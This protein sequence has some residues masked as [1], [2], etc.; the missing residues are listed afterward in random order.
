MSKAVK[1]VTKA[2]TAPIKKVV[3]PINEIRKDVTKA[4]V[5]KAVYNPISQT[6][7]KA[8][9][10][11]NEARKDVT[12]SG[13][14]AVADVVKPL[15]PAGV[16][17]LT[18]ALVASGVG[19]PLAAALAAGTATAGK[20]VDRGASLTQAGKAGLLSGGISGLAGYGGEALGGYLNPM[21]TKQLGSTISPEIIKTYL[22]PALTGGTI[23]GGLGSLLMGQ[24]FGQGFLQGAGNAV[25]GAGIN[26]WLGSQG[27]TD[28]TAK[29][30]LG[31][32]IGAK[33]AP[34]LGLDGESGGDN[35][36]GGGV[37]GG[38][39][40][41]IAGGFDWGA[42]VPYLMGGAGLAGG[43]GLFSLLNSG[44]NNAT[45]TQTGGP[46]VPGTLSLGQIAQPYRPQQN[47][48][49]GAMLGAPMQPAQ[50]PVPTPT[51]QFTGLAA[52]PLAVPSYFGG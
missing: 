7:Q 52:A 50:R 21:L 10:A 20:A 17:L 31:S 27:V 12:R 16:P 39:G 6:A 9:S 43:A 49:Y 32:V 22:T 41:D 14:N 48:G 28:K 44:G 40:R 13:L 15:G 24:N 30:V 8:G 42:L 51:Q 36:G 35:D 33:A 38:A 5:P 23:Q 26:Q 1:S 18:A 11:L 3:S 47:L 34:A 19:A 37:S 46:T 25:L 4:V 2:V 45:G 29:S